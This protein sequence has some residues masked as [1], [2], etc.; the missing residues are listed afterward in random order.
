M[1]FGSVFLSSKCFPVEKMYFIQF[2]FFV[3]FCHSF[4][5]RSK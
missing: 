1:Y 4:N 3:L 5:S 2:S